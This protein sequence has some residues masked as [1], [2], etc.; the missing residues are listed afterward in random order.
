[1]PKDGQAMET[2]KQ[3]MEI[4]ENVVVECVDGACGRS[5]Y[6]VVNPVNQQ[7]THLVV[8]LS[9][10]PGTERMI[11]LDAIKETTADVIRL[12]CTKKELRA[13]P[14]FIEHHFV[15]I[16]KPQYREMY[17]SGSMTGLPFAGS[18]TTGRNYGSGRL[19]AM[20]YAVPARRPETEFVEVKS[21][22]IPPD[23]LAVHRG[24]RVDATDGSVGHV[25][26]FL[27]EPG[28]GCITHLVLREGHL[29]GQRDV[30]I[31]VSEIERCREEED[32][33]YLKLD[34]RG[35]AA[36]PTIAVKHWW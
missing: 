21:E 3:D 5:T 19:M 36:L 1:M 16:D 10:F 25:D 4:P 14:D 34:K 6:V 31:P 28:S 26:E 32:A 12:T 8:K 22:A 17:A 30:T 9:R 13:M 11:P 23:E 35:I 27:V 24:A 7:M 29:W 18:S 33:V 20:P 15:Q 2:P